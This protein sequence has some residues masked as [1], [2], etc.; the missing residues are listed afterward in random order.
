[1]ESSGSLVQQ[2]LEKPSLSKLASSLSGTVL[3]LAAAWSPAAEYP[4]HPV[5]LITPTTAGGAIDS[6]SRMLADRLTEK[7]GQRFVVD[8]RPGASGVIGAS[9]VARAKPDGYTLLF[10]S[11]TSMVSAPLMMKSM[12]YD[13]LVDL[14]PITEVGRIQLVLVVHP[15]MKVNTLKQFIDA[16]KAAPGRIQYASGGE[17]SDHHLSMEL[18]STAAGIKLNHVPYKAGPQGYADL[19]GGHIMAMFIAPGTAAQ[20]VKEG[21]VV[22]LGIS[23]ARTVMGYAGVP[24]VS[25]AIPGYDYEGWFA[26][27]AP[28]GTP[29]NIIARLNTEIRATMVLPDITQKMNAIGIVPK[30]G[31]PEEL[32]AMLISNSEKIGKLMKEIGIEAR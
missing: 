28:K 19:L 13:S 21:K 23:S 8:N 4:N 27:F 25:Q 6:S 10:S 11:N 1:M 29:A 20:H 15:N 12:P 22:A 7:M 2:T 32:T 18:F 9:A 3:I 14:S 17:G 5:T 16:A 30:T 31:T 24:A 26:T